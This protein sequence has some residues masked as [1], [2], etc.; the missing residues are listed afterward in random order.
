MPTAAAVFDQNIARWEQEQSQPWSR[1][2]YDLVHAH[3]MKHLGQ[4]PGHILDAG[5]GNGLDSIPFAE[6]GQRVEIL[7]YSAEMLADAQRRAVAA[8]AMARVGLHL[9]D[10]RAVAQLWPAAQFDLILCHN[11]IQ[12]VDDLPG[13]LGDL[14]AALKPGGLMSIVSINRLS[15]PY[16][17]ALPDGDLGEALVQLEARQQ[18]ARLFDALM[19]CYS[20]DEIMGLLAEAGCRT[21]QDYG[22]RCVCD[23]WG[24]NERKADPAVFQQLEALELAMAERHPYKLLAR[25]FQVIARKT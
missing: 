9:G 15:I 25:Y 13:L 7:D 2:K 11:V 10:V 3:L 1:L 24:D 17:M 5:G 21:E 14:A 23:Y 20:A 16:R 4:S 8:G 22:V 19:R 18:Q 6:Q 12:Y